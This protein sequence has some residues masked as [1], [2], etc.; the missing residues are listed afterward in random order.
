MQD[1]IGRDW[2]GSL[3][4]LTIRAPQGGANECSLM[5]QQILVMQS[6]VVP[7]AKT[8][9]SAIFEFSKYSLMQTLPHI[10]WNIYSFAQQCNCDE[11]QHRTHGPSFIIVSTESAPHTQPFELIQSKNQ[12]CIAWLSE[13]E[14]FLIKNIELEGIEFFLSETD[15]LPNAIS[16]TGWMDGLDLW[17]GAILR[18]PLVANK[19][20]VLRNNSKYCSWLK[21]FARFQ[22]RRC[23]QI[24]NALQ[25][26][27]FHTVKASLSPF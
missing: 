5:C 11:I 18:A 17:A 22:F 7:M 1:G 25:C 9:Q 10:F 14:L 8:L 15:F 4:H 3:N 26:L 16:G 23:Q 27:T 12:A 20:I 6:A 2:I 21:C 24:L 13:I 19:H